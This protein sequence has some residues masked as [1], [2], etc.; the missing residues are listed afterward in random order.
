[1]LNV[2]N[3]FRVSYFMGIKLMVRLVATVPNNFKHVF[4]ME[5]IPHFSRITNNASIIVLKDIMLMK[6][7]INVCHVT[8]RNAEIV[9]KIV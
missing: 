1:M 7:Q 9:K 6:K 2:G 4:N 5:S 3:V 8:R